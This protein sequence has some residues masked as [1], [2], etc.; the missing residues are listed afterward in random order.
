ML[1]NVSYAENYKENLV[2]SLFQTQLKRIQ[3]N[4]KKKN[5]ILGKS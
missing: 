1:Y 3:Q 2:L 4:S 5:E